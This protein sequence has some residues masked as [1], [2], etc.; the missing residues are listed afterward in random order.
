AQ[1]NLGALR[2]L[3]CHGCGT[4]LESRYELNSTHLTS[5]R[6][7]PWQCR[8]KCC[9]GCQPGYA[10]QFHRKRHRCRHWRANSKLDPRC[11]W[12][13]ASGLAIGTVVSAFLTGGVSGGLT[14]LVVAISESKDGELET[15][16]RRNRHGDSYDGSLWRAGEETPIQTGRRSR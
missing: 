7:S 12:P 2:L 15:C 16:N 1:A 4:L 8:R 5:H 3:T 10:G 6:C 11:G 9:E 14:A 13:A